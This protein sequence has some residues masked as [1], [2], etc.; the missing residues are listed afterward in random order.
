MIA[1]SMTALAQA[2]EALPEYRLSVSFVPGENLLKG[3]AAIV[4]PGEKPWSIDTGVLKVLDAGLDGEALD[5]ESIKSINRDKGINLATGGTLKISYEVL[6]QGTEADVQNVGVAGSVV[7]TEGISLT[8]GWYPGVKGLARYSLTALVPGEFTAVSEAEEVSVSDT[9]EG[10][11]YAFHFPHP[12]EGMTLAAGRYTVASD[13]EGDTEVFAYFFEEDTALADTYIDYTKRYLRMYSGML[14]PY[15]FKRFSV[16]ENFLPTGYSMPTYTLLGRDVVRLPFIVETSLG[17]EILHQW[18]GNYVYGDPEG[19]NWLEG[20]TTYLADHLYEEL[21]GEGTLYRKKILA[22]YQ[23]YVTPERAIALKDFAARTDPATKAVGYGKC[24]MLFHMLKGLVGEDT[25]NNILKAFIEKNA[26]KKTSWDDV[27]EA[28]KQ[29]SDIGLEEFFR[30]WLERTDVPHIRV[31]DPRVIYLEGEPHV[32]FTLK[33]NG[34]YRLRLKVKIITEGGEHTEVLEVE[35]EK[36]RFRIPVE[37]TPTEVVLDPDYDLMRGLWP[38]EFPPSAA[39]LLGAE[40][41]L[42]VMP[43]KAIET[44]AALTG[45]LKE[46]GFTVKLE[47]EIKD[48][49]I[50]TSGTLLLGTDGP[51]HRRLFGLPVE[52][53]EKGFTLTVMKNP[54]NPSKVVAIAHGIDTDEVDAAAKKIFRYGK[55]SSLRFEGGR[56]TLKEIAPSDTGMRVNL[57]HRVSGIRPER[58]LDLDE[59]I[60]DVIEKPIIYVGESHTNYEDHR[61]QLEVI[62]A[63]KE[64][65]RKFAVGMEM[66]QR[67]FQEALDDYLSEETTEK[68]FLK[69]SEYFTRWKFDYHLYREIVDYARAH[70]IPV[71]ALNTDSDIIK[72]VSDGGLDALSEEEREKI[73]AD[74]DMSDETYRKRLREVFK[75]HK[76]SGEKNFEFFYQSQILWDETMAHSVEEFLKENPDHQM[77]VL[78]GIGHIAYGRG[79]PKRAYRLNGKDY[80]LLINSNIETIDEGMADYV[81]FPESLKPPQMPLIGVMLTEA[82]GKVS[83]AKLSPGGPAQLAGLKRKDMFVSMDGLEIE[84]VGDIKIAL[85][86]REEGDTVKVRVIRKRFLFGKKEIELEVTLR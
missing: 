2:G 64:S 85:F 18:L 52:T 1:I 10:R 44:Y 54:L 51:I 19:G 84:D 59:I 83:I 33:Q 20:L 72:K 76:K 23:S 24:A 32:S 57:S 65:G 74:M 77:V 66:F 17:H 56:N 68:E 81:L 38:D 39:R 15:P 31:E 42:L 6:L 35:K 53:V 71:V 48:E 4:L 21:K 43:E 28:F 45:M 3:E 29:A 67:Q 27:R 49:D 25:F 63:L 50:S 26:F 11:M 47:D 79:I 7:S 70:D 13:T 69:A 75:L 55:Y 30:Q 62:R 9:P 78:A 8:G 60:R 86:D 16:V 82:D 5:A 36:E 34:P 41:R 37:G 58:S 40:K 61:V 14:G 80:A 12:A 22:D 73:P 46:E